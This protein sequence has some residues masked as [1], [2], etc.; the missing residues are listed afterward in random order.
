[1]TPDNA[2]RANRSKIVGRGVK[3]TGE[4]MVKR[5]GLRSGCPKT[6][7]SAIILTSLY[8]PAV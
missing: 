8:P 7:L 2:V 4:K 1:M 5:G 3:M 6:I